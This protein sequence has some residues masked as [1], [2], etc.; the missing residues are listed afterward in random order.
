MPKRILNVCGVCLGQG[1]SEDGNVIIPI[2][3]KE[4]CKMSKDMK[5]AVRH[6]VKNIKCANCGAYGGKE[7]K[8]MKCSGCHAVHYCSSEC[9]KADWKKHKLECKK[10]DK[11]D[12][13][14]RKKSK[15]KS[16]KATRKSTRKS[17]KATR[18]SKRK[19][20]KTIRKSS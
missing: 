12:Y 16:R 2:Q 10:S 18:K 14:F 5:R 11:K 8:L 13:A 7:G 9:Q 19:S 17:R 6:A 20:R 3:H 15:R 1:I 4:D